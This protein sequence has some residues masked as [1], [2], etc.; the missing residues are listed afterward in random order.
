MSCD[1]L[2][3][4]E[5]LSDWVSN[6]KISPIEIDHIVVVYLDTKPAE[7]MEQRKHRG[8]AQK[9]CNSNNTS[10]ELKVIVMQVV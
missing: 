7:G 6:F 3:D 4:L 9:P 1:T 8:I 5:K 10:L 2:I